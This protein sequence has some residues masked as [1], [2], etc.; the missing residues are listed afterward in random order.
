MKI[1]QF[2]V[3][4]SNMKLRLFKIINNDF[5]NTK[6]LLELIIQ[7]DKNPFPAGGWD[8]AKENLGFYSLL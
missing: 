4:K 5:I 7:T 2:Y 1:I 6:E 8:W 3:S